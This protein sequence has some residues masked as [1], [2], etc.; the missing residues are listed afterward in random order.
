MSSDLLRQ[1]CQPLSSLIIGGSSWAS[2]PWGKLT[3]GS[4]G[5]GDR[6]TPLIHLRLLQLLIGVQPMTQ[7]AERRMDC[8]GARL[9]IALASCDGVLRISITVAKPTT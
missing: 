6:L 2:N 4:R 9:E 1:Q 7:V 5:P 3:L 8:E